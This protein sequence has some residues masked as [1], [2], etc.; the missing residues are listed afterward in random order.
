MPPHWG[1]RRSKAARRMCD[2]LKRKL[3]AEFTQTHRNTGAP[4]SPALPCKA[5]AVL[6]PPREGYAD[7]HVTIAAAHPRDI[8]P[9]TGNF[10]GE[11]TTNKLNFTQ[12]IKVPE[13]EATAH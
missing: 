2:R 12:E 8:M 6:I 3:F 13:D 1:R 4:Q 11:V 9:V 10:F 5:G 7:T